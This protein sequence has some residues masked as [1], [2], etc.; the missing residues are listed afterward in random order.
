MQEVPND[1]RQFDGEFA[2]LMAAHGG[3]V[4]AFVLTLLPNPEDRDDTL[5]E[6]HLA[7]WSKRMNYDRSR[8]F[9]KWAC[10]VAYKQVLR[11]RSQ[12]AKTRLLFSDEAVHLLAVDVMASLDEFD[13]RGEALERCL[14]SLA[15]RD[16]KLVQ[17]RYREGLSI[18]RISADLGLTE[19]AMYKSLKRIRE[20]L[21]DCVK[22]AV[23]AERSGPSA[24]EFE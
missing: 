3:A 11:R 12:L 14:Q 15:A 10:G 13:E 6:T 22:R 19:S 2:S 5:Q 21:R 18:S 17:A 7:L 24:M 8:P 1:D 23:N 4:R 9:V 20:S 16:H